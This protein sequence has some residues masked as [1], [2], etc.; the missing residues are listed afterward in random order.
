MFRVILTEKFPI[1]AVV[2]VTSYDWD[3]DRSMEANNTSAFNYRT[4]TGSSTLSKHARGFA[5]DLNPVQNPYSK[6]STILPPGATYDDNAPGT[7]TENSP[8][9]Q[10]FKE[11]GWEWG[12]NWNTLKDYQH[13]EKT[14]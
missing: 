2:P 12:G 11:L 5:I 9:V 14:P 6:G 7:L 8:I 13:F 1:Q 3:D 10:K 4:T